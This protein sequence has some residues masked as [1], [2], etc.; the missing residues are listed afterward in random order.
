MKTVFS[1][2]PENEYDYD[3]A[4]ILVEELKKL[5]YKAESDMGI[6]QMKILSNA[7]RQEVKIVLLKAEEIFFKEEK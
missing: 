7:S 3:F 2:N 5:N 1:Y 6:S 4:D